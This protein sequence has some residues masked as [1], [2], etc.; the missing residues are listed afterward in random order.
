MENDEILRPLRLTAQLLELHD[1]N[2]FKIRSYQNA[3]I[4]LERVND[5][6]ADLPPAQLAAIQGVGKS[7]AAS[8]AA[9]REGGSF[10][11]LENLIAK[12]PEGVLD[13]LRIKGIGPKK[14]RTLWRELGVETTDTLLQAC[15]E[16]RVAQL[17]G[18]G[19]KTQENIKQALLF[20][21]QAAGKL[22][23]AEAEAVAG[24][25]LQRLRDAGIQAGPAGQLARKSDIVDTLQLL[26]AAP[27]PAAVHGLLDGLPGLR[28]DDRTTAP[29][30]WRGTLEGSEMP[31]EVLIT[32]PEKFV[33]QSFIC[34]AAPDHL[35]YRDEKGH[36]LLQIALHGKFEAEEAIY[37]QAGLPY[38]IPEL[39][40]GL[41]EFDLAK[42]GKLGNLVRNE[43]LKGIL[44]NHSTYSDGRHTLAE[45]ANYC[46]ELGYQYLGISDHS[47]SAY[48]AGGLTEEFVA[49]QHREIDELNG[50][51]A[52]FRI[53]KGIE[54]DILNDGSL[55]YDKDVLA[56]FDFI[57]ASV[58]SN[59]K[60]DEAKAT[61]RL[62]KAVEN[63]YT[64]ILGHPTGRLLLRR[65]GYPIDHQKVIDA[66]A[67]NEVIIEI[68]ANPWRL[69]I[70]WHWLPYALNKGVLI[71][72]NP[73][74]HE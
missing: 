2:P 34:S 61:A 67:A 68:N 73:D 25:L 24:G 21:R 15:E 1:E 18:F 36:T 37:A 13:M 53:F 69:D 59:L 22:H 51:L 66:C 58:H 33:N 41:F 64:T 44:H 65:E 56:S 29:F 48:Y 42:A 55:D 12:T 27:S 54:S 23:Y 16:N 60:M 10:P 52:P 57:V 45:M 8:I 70:D 72:I 39:R 28:R 74:A 32:R 50:Q 9:I 46:R 20:T 4:A 47:K 6:L 11:E 30:S 71:S 19:E 26:A 40:E 31:L 3:V 5:N 17:K 35:R 38:I 14:V 49:K 7:I 43:D 63:P 62:I